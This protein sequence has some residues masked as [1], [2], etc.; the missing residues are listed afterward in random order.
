MQLLLGH[1]FG[2]K[3]WYVEHA[4]VE[5]DVRKKRVLLT[6]K[7][8]PAL[9]S[10]QADDMVLSSPTRKE[11]GRV[12]GLVGHRNAYVTSLTCGGIGCQSPIL[13]ATRNP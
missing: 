1:F 13:M 6:L 10:S 11:H 4:V 12:V 5:V 2:L 9:L 8:I 7:C 3:H